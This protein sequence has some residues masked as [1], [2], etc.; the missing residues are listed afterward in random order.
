MWKI[1][2]G[3]AGVAVLAFFIL[4]NGNPDNEADTAAVARPGSSAAVASDAD[5]GATTRAATASQATPETPEVRFTN[6][7]A[8]QR[9]IT[10]ST[11]GTIVVNPRSSSSSASR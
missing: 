3:V 9:R 5:G 11:T 2:A 10:K 6:Y 1:V 4:K 7:E 8:P